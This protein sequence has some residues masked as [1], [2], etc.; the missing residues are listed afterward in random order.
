[1]LSKPEDFELKTP[2]RV[3]LWMKTFENDTFRI[4]WRSDDHDISLPEFFSNT[5]PRRRKT[6]LLFQSETTLSKFLRQGVDGAS[7]SLKYV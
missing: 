7:A 2:A 3:L 6:F 1:M 5:S 4:R